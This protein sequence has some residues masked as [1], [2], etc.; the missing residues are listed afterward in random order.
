MQQNESPLIRALTEYYDGNKILSTKFKCACLANCQMRRESAPEQVIPGNL[1][2]AREQIFNKFVQ[3]KSSFIGP[4]Y[5]NARALGIPRLLFVSADP[6]SV[7][8]SYQHNYV[9]SVN[10]TPA[11]VRKISG[12]L[13][14][15]GTRNNWR[16]THKMACRILLEYPE[17]A[18][19]SPETAT[20]YFAH[21][22]AAKCCENKRGKGEASIRLFKN[23]RTYLRGEIDLLAPDVIVT[24][25][26][27]AKE[28]VEFAYSTS[29]EFGEA[30][31]V[32]AKSGKALW[33]P[34]PHP[35]NRRGEYKKQREHEWGPA[36]EKFAERVRDFISNRDS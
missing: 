20:P 24:H 11:S 18:Q 28:G 25:G 26:P 7:L 5:E 9:P 10:R 1:K 8:H 30:N 27:R 15:F 36:W 34:L 19:L 17:C 22:N 4:H 21:V 31:I 14:E 33:L 12:D 2:E 32:R 6:G 13:G 16:Q 35:S 3:M 29:A 23:C